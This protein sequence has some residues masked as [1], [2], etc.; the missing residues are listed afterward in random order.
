MPAGK[1]IKIDSEILDLRA[2]LKKE[3]NNIDIKQKI[4]AL[5]KERETVITMIHRAQRTGEKSN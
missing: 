1:L 3:P 2:Q 5:I 4:A